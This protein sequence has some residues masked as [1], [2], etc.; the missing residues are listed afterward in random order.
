MPQPRS[1]TS[2]DPTTSTKGTSPQGLIHMAKSTQSP[3]ARE[4][5]AKSRRDALHDL[6]GLILVGPSNVFPFKPSTA[7][8]LFD[9]AVGLLA[10]HDKTKADAL[11]RY[12]AYIARMELMQLPPG[13]DNA[14]TVKWLLSEPVI[15]AEELRTN[16]HKYSRAVG[17]QSCHPRTLRR[18]NELLRAYGC[19]HKY[20]SGS[21][22]ERGQRPAWARDH[23]MAMIGEAQAVP[24]WHPLHDLGRYDL[25]QD[26]DEY[27]SLSKLSA[28]VIAR[29]H[30]INPD[31]LL[32]RLLPRRRW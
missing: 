12:A 20:P 6:V 18:Q 27:T 15:S 13:A 26:I 32:K 22:T 7:Q 2:P 10:Q 21:L 1:R 16:F 14:A 23:L 25:D 17:K 19:A 29:L 30:G 28:L 4:G 3:Q 9:L 5:A 8:A 24:C 31:S 11:R